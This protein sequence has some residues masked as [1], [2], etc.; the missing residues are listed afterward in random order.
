M[1][2]AILAT[3]S[4]KAQDT[5]QSGGL[6]EEVMVTAR[7]VTE[8]MQSVPVAVNSMTESDMRALGVATTRDVLA[9]T[10]GATVT[11]A[12]ADVSGITLRGIS[13]G[14]RGAS[15]DSGVM[16]M[17]DGEVISRGFMHNSNM[18]DM[19]RVEVLRGP[20]GTT[21]GRNATAGVVNF[22]NER[23]SQE[24][25]SRII[26]DAGDYDTFAV[27]GYV[28]GALSDTI[29]GRL[30]GKYS[31]RDGYFEDAITGDDIDA[32]DDISLRGQL[33]FEPSDDLVI[34]LKAHWTDFHSDSFSP[35]KNNDSSIPIEFQSFTGWD[36]ISY[37][38][39]S[40]DPWK[41]V[42]TET[43]GYD[44]EIWGGLLDI[45]KDFGDLSLVSLTTYRD[46]EDEST[47]D[48]GGTPYAIAIERAANDATTFSQE[49]RLNNQNQDDATFGWQLGVYYLHEE[50]DRSAD[51]LFL[52][53][54]CEFYPDECVN[55]PP[56]L[57]FM[58]LPTMD[59]IAT[60]QFLIQE[61]E[62]DSYGVFGEVTY[63]FTDQT[64][65]LVG[66]RY[67]YDKKDYYGITD[68]EGAI[69]FFFIDGGRV[70]SDI[71]DS[72]DDFS[73]KV[74]LTH[75]FT[76]TIMAYGS[77]ATGYKSGAFNAEPASADAVNAVDPEYVTTYEIGAKM[78]LLDDHLRLNITV[79]QSDYEDI[80]S[81][82]TTGT[83]VTV[84]KNVGEA[85][86]EGYEIEGIAY[87]TENLSLQFAYADYDHEYTEFSRGD[88]DTG[89]GIVGNP[90]QNA[91]DWTATVALNYDIQLDSG[92]EITL[93]GD[94][95]GA[96]EITTRF[97]DT[98]PS[99]IK[100]SVDMFNAVAKYTSTD[101]DW[102]VAIWGRNLTEEE[103]VATIGPAFA[104]TNQG[105]RGYG[106][107]RTYGVTLEYNF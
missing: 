72:W 23:P 98:D 106:A 45:Q 2:A 35:R 82:F 91:P 105:S 87:F 38:E 62:L 24:F 27:E 39:V 74:S 99:S 69:S 80:Q 26:V 31:E 81:S 9:F 5:V 102:S 41:V 52:D 84:A 20:Q 104:L 86:I 90:I 28:N 8:S 58:Q 65:L 77:V 60:T 40:D 100:P 48:L 96:G 107:P 51:T 6:L 32:Q 95:R 101:M 33:L 44:R 55:P 17:E 85:E 36:F 89:E 59:A 29:S 25:A 42:N 12:V 14:N 64:S 21:F 67:S 56:F 63:D 37:S 13:S 68:A 7:K 53:G 10:P 71:D 66:G 15:E 94:Y 34:L 83:A 54:L 3:Q 75:H 73:G 49:F 50:H 79:F 4:A 18:Y 103:E 16:V 92:A 76:D 1:T 43:D 93:R 61:N 97:D 46:G 57:G 11:S 30:S 70:E 78:D 19:A 88:G 47:A 22:I